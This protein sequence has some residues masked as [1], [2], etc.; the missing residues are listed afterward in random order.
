MKVAGIEQQLA[1]NTELTA[2]VK[3]NTAD[4]VQAWQSVRGGLK[5]LGWLGLV[6]KWVTIIAAAV[7]AVAAA[8]YAIMHFGKPPG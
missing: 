8:A 3:Q 2:Q 5:V 4:I 6:A 1:D 7:S